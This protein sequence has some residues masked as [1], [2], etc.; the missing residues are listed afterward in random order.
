MK[1]R[2]CSL[3][4]GTQQEMKGM[5]KLDTDLKDSYF[6]LFSIDA[7]QAELDTKT[8]SMKLNWYPNK[9]WADQSGMLKS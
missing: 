9:C 3:H 8:K 5:T 1:H 4:F 2:K 7:P 6:K